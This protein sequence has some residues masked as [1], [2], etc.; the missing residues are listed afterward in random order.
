MGCTG[1]IGVDAADQSGG[2][3]L[4]CFATNL[5]VKILDCNKNFI[6]YKIIDGDLFYFSYFFYGDPNMEGRGKV[7]E[8]LKK[9][10]NDNPGPAILLGDFNQ[11]EFA[12]QKEVVENIC[13]EHGL[14]VNGEETGELIFE[15]LDRAYSMRNGGVCFPRSQ[16]RIAKKK[17]PYKIEAWCL[18]KYEVKEIIKKKWAVKTKG[19]TMFQAM[20]KQEAIS[21]ACRTWCLNRKKE[22]GITWDKFK[23]ELE[24]TREQTLRSNTEDQLLYWKQRAKIKWDS[25]GDQCTSFFFRSVETRKGRNAKTSLKRRMEPGCVTKKKFL[26][27]PGK[28]KLFNPE[29]NNQ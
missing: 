2:L 15:Q 22:L 29:K 20:R 23:E 28:F 13:Q 6:L 7:W 9:L 1:T 18:E 11:V 12:D 5:G 24:A 19:S 26:T 25:L 27:A 10:L 14:L 4:A 17:R 8:S 3:F 21:T 16:L